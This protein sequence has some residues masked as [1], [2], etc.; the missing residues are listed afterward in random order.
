MSLSLTH[1][2]THTHTQVT[3][4]Q[5]ASAWTHASAT[6]GIKSHGAKMNLPPSARSCCVASANSKTCALALMAIRLNSRSFCVFGA[7]V[8]PPRT[9]IYIYKYIYFAALN[10][11]TRKR[12]LSTQ[13]VG[14]ETEL[15]FFFSLL[16]L[17]ARKYAFFF[18]VLHARTWKHART[19]KYAMRLWSR[20]LIY[21]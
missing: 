7:A 10:L 4:T 9:R 14:D 21:I 6:S 20:S 18:P 16:R 13:A 12:A 8:L 17:R 3:C 5:C 2:H 11:G 19:R 15:K 1:T